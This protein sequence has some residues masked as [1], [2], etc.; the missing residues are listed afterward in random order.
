LNQAEF[1]NTIAEAEKLGENAVNLLKSFEGMIKS[2]Y[3]NMNSEQAIKLA[4]AMNESRLD[5]RVKDFEK[6]IKDL[7]KAFK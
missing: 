4:Q 5:E 3:G 6:Q 7:S 1:K 2:Q